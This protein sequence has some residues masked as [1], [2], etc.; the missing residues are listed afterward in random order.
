MA[1]NGGL[2]AWW[3]HLAAVV[4]R[5]TRARVRRCDHATW[6]AMIRRRPTHERSLALPAFTHVAWA[7]FRYNIFTRENFGSLTGKQK[8]GR[9][10]GATRSLH[11]KLSSDPRAIYSRAHYEVDPAKGCPRVG[12]ALR[13]SRYITAEASLAPCTDHD[14]EFVNS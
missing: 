12:F 8:R 2:S 6:L 3:F 4:N 7:P 11:T 14:L 1:I 5:T 10:G 9:E 13:P